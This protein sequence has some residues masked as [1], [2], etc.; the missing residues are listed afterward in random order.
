[1]RE[2]LSSFEQRDSWAVISVSFFLYGRWGFFLDTELNTLIW[3][4][5]VSYSFD[6]WRKIH[7]LFFV[8]ISSFVLWLQCSCFYVKRYY[9]KERS[10]SLRQADFSYLLLWLLWGEQS[11]QLVFSVMFL[12]TYLCDS[13]TVFIAEDKNGGFLKCRWIIWSYWD[14]TQGLAN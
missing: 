5:Y 8:T 14:K 12:C 9:Q 2:E 10:W 11:F 4:S 3:M 7:P 6:L 13:I 1:M